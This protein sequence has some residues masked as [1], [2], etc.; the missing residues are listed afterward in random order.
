MFY[1]LGGVKYCPALTEERRRGMNKY[2]AAL[3]VLY[4]ERS[5]LL[6]F[7]SIQELKQ[8]QSAIELLEKEG[9]EQK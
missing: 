9:N 5:K 8:L 1:K 4:Y 2:Q 3:D 7:A 6:S